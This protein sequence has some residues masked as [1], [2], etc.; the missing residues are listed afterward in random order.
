MLAELIE[1]GIV[2]KLQ[3]GKISDLVGEPYP[4]RYKQE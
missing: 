1:A 2:K 4:L 3:P